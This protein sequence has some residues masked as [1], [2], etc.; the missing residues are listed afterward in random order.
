MI[1]EFSVVS[2]E[3]AEAMAAGARAAS[4]ADIGIAI[5]G[6]AG[7]EADP[8]REAGEAYIGYAYGDKTGAVEVRTSRNFRKWNRNYFVLRMLRTV[9]KLIK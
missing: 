3:V 7:P 4:G 5:T 1:K 9:Y 6:Y 8:E 2:P